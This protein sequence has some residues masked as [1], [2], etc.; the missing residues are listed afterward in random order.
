LAIGG[1]Y[2]RRGA[3]SRGLR[4]RSIE[5]TSIA[6]GGSTAPAGRLLRRLRAESLSRS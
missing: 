6:L 4:C 5:V 3:G 2:F 1:A